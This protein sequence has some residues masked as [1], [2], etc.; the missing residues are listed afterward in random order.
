MKTRRW[1]IAGAACVALG[2]A[3][4]HAQTPGEPP[5]SSSRAD[6]GVVNPPNDTSDTQIAKRPQGIDAEFV[7]KAALAGKS[8][9]QA[10][11]LAGERSATPDVR[12]FAKRMVDD[13]G[14]LNEALRRL[15][16]RKGLPVQAA[17]I[18]DPDVEALRGKSGRDFDVAYLAAAGPAAHRRAIL[19]FENE[20]RAGR[21]PDLRAFAVQT[22]PMLRQHFADARAVS[23]KVGAAR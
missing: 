22:L 12:A 14:R 11:Q 21:D 10:G 5:A 9:V 20:A 23:R 3:A 1:I 8:E 16:E 19:L 7:D 17:Q 13:H 4:L 15:A 2:A 6:R 18:I